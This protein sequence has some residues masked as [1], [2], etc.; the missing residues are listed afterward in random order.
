VEPE[1]RLTKR[2]RQE[3]ARQERKQRETRQVKE[4]EQ[5]RWLVI[6]GVIAAIAGI[7]ALLWFTQEGPVETDIVVAASAVEQAATTAGCEELPLAPPQTT[8]HLSEP[9]PP[10]E[11]LYPDRPAH[12]GPHFAGVSPVGTFDSPLDERLVLHNLEHGAI[13]VW[14]DADQITPQDRNALESWADERNRAGFHGRGG[15]AIIVSPYPQALDSG[16]TLAFRA[17]LVAVDCDGF[18]QNV[19]D[20]FLAQ[21][22]GT[23]GVAPERAFAPY[24]D[25]VVELDGTPQFPGDAPDESEDDDT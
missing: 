15:A 1:E 21:H 23:R 5:R 6:V 2:E 22:Y 18:D 9:A 14:Y 13:T 20:A 12:S 4:K 19:A 17:W 16:K 10:P 7:G 11:Q 25:G 3:R 8:A 24:P